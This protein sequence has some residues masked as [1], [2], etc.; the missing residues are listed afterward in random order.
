MDN[1]LKYLR[2]KMDIATFEYLVTRNLAEHNFNQISKGCLF[3]L[4]DLYDTESIHPCRLIRVVDEKDF[5]IE[6]Y[7]ESISRTYICSADNFTIRE[8]MEEKQ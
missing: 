3:G 4:P 6:A 7:E 5:V 8:E 2:D 1:S